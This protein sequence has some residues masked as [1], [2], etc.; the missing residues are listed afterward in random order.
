MTDIGRKTLAVFYPAFMGGGAEALA[1]WMLEALKDDYH[2]TLFTVA[3]PNFPKLDSMYGTALAHQNIQ[4][5]LLPPELP[6]DLCKF[7]IANS[8]SLRMVFF[9]LLIRYFKQHAQ[10]YDIVLSAFN[11]V[12][13]GKP[14]IQYLHWVRVVEGK[15]IYRKISDFSFDRLKQNVSLANSAYTAEAV[16]RAYGIPAKVVF[17]P[18]PGDFPMVDWAD[19]E[20]AFLYSGRLVKAKQPDR[21]IRILSQ[22]RQ[23]GFD[24]KLHITAGGGGSYE[25]RYERRVRKLVQENADWVTLHEN[26]PYSGYT[27]LLGQCRYGIHVKREPFGISIAEMVKAGLIPF[28]KSKGGQTEIVGQHNTTL[29]FE[30]DAEAIEKIISVLG[31]PDQ[32]TS[33]LQALE[34]RKPLF[35]TTRFMNEVKLIVDSFN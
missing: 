6:S 15:P 11:G 16:Q 20:N 27:Q 26:L 34:E 31:S 7:L 3:Q 14:G 9:H 18:V 19:K 32:Q 21:I 10:D 4:V 8:K 30:N 28:V 25:L 5:A 24:I 2:I 17:P 35:S 23:A 22:V 33:L 29:L 1:L 12:D 13:L